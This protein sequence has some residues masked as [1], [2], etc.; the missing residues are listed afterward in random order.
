MGATIHGHELM[1]RWLLQP[2]ARLSSSRANLLL[3]LACDWLV[4]L[5]LCGAALRQ[6]G[7]T[8]P[9]VLLIVPLGLLAFSFIEYA[10]HRWL[11]HGRT[12]PLRAGHVQHHRNPAGHDALPFFL[13]P[14]VL[15]ALA[16]LLTLAL[17][18]V[19]AMLLAG[20]IAV[21]YALYGSSHAV[22]HARRFH[23]PLLAR[24]QQFHDVHHTHPSR[25]F[26]VTTGLWDVLLGTCGP[27][28]GLHAPR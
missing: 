5:L 10:A 9:A 6:G 18:A 27:G 13:P 16:A 19:Q 4:A 23:T 15:L 28:R 25:N 21:G 17:P 24:W 1:R 12:G 3:G 2:L 20:V 11:F 14:L 8:V 26:G 7:L 22:L